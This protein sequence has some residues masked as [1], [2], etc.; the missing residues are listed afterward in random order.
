MVIKVLW[1]VFRN[2][3]YSI[4]ATG[5]A[6]MV[7]SATLLLPNL[8]AI[9]QIFATDVISFGAK[10][11]FLFSLYGTLFTN[12]NVLSALNLILIA[13]FFGVNIS[14]VTYYIRRQQ[15]AS[16]N[17]KVHAASLGGIIS[18]ILGIGCAACGSVVLTALL[19]AFGG[20]GFILL[21]PFHG[22]EFGLMGV[23]LL[24]VSIYYVC[25][26]IN[27]PLVCR[28]NSRATSVDG[29]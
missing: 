17:A 9:R 5:V 3:R 23:I 22:A 6:F 7:L 2:A 13:V 19:G 16:K 25:A 8:P 11:S 20:G 28:M 18:G 12:F 24:A 10:F 15:I 26:R 4:M 29:A 21:L 14:L 27:D 1:R